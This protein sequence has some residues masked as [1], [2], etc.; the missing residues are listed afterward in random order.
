[1]HKDNKTQAARHSNTTDTYT[2]VLLLLMPQETVGIISVVRSAEF[3]EQ[4]HTLLLR[5]DHSRSPQQHK[6][7]RQSTVAE[8]ASATGYINPSICANKV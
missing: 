6:L 2:F 3:C 4:Q 8:L 7:T 1:M 5:F